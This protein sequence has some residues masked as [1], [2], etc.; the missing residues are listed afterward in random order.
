MDI[1]V[2]NLSFN[3]TNDDLKKLFEEFGNIASAVVVMR[4]E[5]KI[6]KSRGFGFV[7]MLDEQQ[8]QAAIAALNGKELMGR[9]L[10]ISPARPKAETKVK[11]EPKEKKQEPIAVKVKQYDSEDV[12]AK[13]PQ[14]KPFI[15]KP[16]T[17]MG[18]RRTF[19]YLKRRGL[20]EIPE[21]KQWKGS[22]D[23]PMRWR[24]KKDKVRPWEKQKR[25][26][27][28][29]RKSEGGIKS[30]E[31]PEADSKPWSKREGTVKP[32][33][34]TAKDA[35]PWAKRSKRVQKI[36]FKGNNRQSENRGNFNR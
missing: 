34:K 17:Y 36:R 29:W 25:D 30:W 12:V 28:P 4:K 3:V 26:F 15:R 35:K 33:N 11:T 7:Q 23:N 16:G 31:K 2:G 22:R 18:G 24:K 13:R 14:F 27:K 32:W 20:T 5:K 19:S 8:A 10:D 9:I 6:P 21:A 1:F